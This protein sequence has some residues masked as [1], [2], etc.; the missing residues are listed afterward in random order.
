MKE[1]GFTDVWKIDH[2]GNTYAMK[3]STFDPAGERWLPVPIN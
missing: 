1:K 3:H 2:H